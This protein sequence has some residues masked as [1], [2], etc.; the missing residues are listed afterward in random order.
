MK[1]MNRIITYLLLFFVL[2]THSAIAMDVHIPSV[3][4]QEPHLVIDSD[5]EPTALELENK[6]CGDLGGH[7]SH[8]SS[9]I[10]GIVSSISLSSLETKA[11]FS[12]TEKIV[13][14]AHPQAPPLRPPKA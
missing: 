3:F 1:Y 5:S 9:H 6:D 2:F 8:S 14:V 10:S 12:S 13:P 11:V 7:C 4:S